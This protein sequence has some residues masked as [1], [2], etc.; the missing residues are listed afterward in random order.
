MTKICALFIDV[1]AI[2]SPSKEKK[3]RIER[4]MASKSIKE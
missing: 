2:F 1:T 4:E 3:Q